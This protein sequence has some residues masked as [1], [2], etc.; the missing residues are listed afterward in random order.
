MTKH[1]ILRQIEVPLILQSLIRFSLI[2]T[3]IPEAFSAVASPKLYADATQRSPLY[4]LPL[5][6]ILRAFASPFTG[7]VRGRSEW[8]R[9]LRV[10]DRA[11]LQVASQLC[12]ACD[13]WCFCCHA[14]EGL[15]GFL[16]FLFFFF[17]WLFRCCGVACCLDSG[18]VL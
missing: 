11:S 16:F 7:V 13:R 12:Q 15:L 4:A 8:S 2:R 17:F 3:Q 9:T 5:R 6:T 1:S 10:T 18:S 14:V